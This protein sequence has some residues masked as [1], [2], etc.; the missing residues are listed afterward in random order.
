M[1]GCSITGASRLFSYLKVQAKADA[2]VTKAAV[3]NLVTKERAANEREI[4]EA[5]AELQYQIRIS[6]ERHSAVAALR[7][8]GAGQCGMDKQGEAGSV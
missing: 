1:V 7:N 8:E 5:N 2:A 4:V 6:Q 3:T